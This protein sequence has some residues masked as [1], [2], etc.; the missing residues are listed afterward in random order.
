MKNKVSANATATI[1]GLQTD[2]VHEASII[3]SEMCDEVIKSCVYPQ[4]GNM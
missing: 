3:D 1:M 4:N 2:E